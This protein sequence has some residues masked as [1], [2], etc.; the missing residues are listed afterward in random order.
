MEPHK[1][2]VFRSPV[3]CSATWRKRGFLNTRS[4]SPRGIA[5]KSSPPLA[6]LERLD[7]F[8]TP[9]TLVDHQLAV[10]FN[11]GKLGGLLGIDAIVPLT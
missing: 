7:V 10:G 4:H 5:S 1:V 3:E 9:A 8:S 2:I 11:R 6:E